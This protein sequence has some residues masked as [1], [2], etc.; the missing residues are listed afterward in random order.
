MNF[1]LK[2]ELLNL[3]CQNRLFQKGK[4]TLENGLTVSITRLSLKK[5]TYLREACTQKYEHIENTLRTNLFMATDMKLY[6]H[7]AGLT[8]WKY[9]GSCVA[10]FNLPSTPIHA[11]FHK[12]DAANFVLKLA[13]MQL[14]EAFSLCDV[15][16]FNEIVISDEDANISLALNAIR[17]N[18]DLPVACLVY[19]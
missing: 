10:T 18:L 2:L 14:K 11:I 12:S 16:V 19:E 1:R 15:I 13:S 6:S 3:R 17:H 7:L 4:L 5:C 8:L 9:R